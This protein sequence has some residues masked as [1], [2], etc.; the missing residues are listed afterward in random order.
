MSGMHALVPTSAD[1]R[2]DR[3][4]ALADPPPNPTCLAGQDLADHL[5][6]TVAGCPHCGRGRLWEAC[7]RR[8][9]FGSMHEAAM[10]KARL[11][12]R[13]SRLARRLVTGPAADR[14]DQ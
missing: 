8:P 1:V 9:C 5:V 10:T 11:V 12:V 3:V 7:A 6:G 14:A 4:C 13:L 2:T